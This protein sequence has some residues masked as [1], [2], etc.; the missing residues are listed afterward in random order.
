MAHDFRVFFM[1]HTGCIEAK[2]TTNKSILPK[3]LMD[4]MRE[5][6][7]RS[8]EFLDLEINQEHNEEKTNHQRVVTSEEFENIVAE[9]WQYLATLSN[10]KIIVKNSRGSDSQ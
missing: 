3:I 1:G 4:E 8:Q 10:G 2:Y 6:F 7:R 5:S 9:G